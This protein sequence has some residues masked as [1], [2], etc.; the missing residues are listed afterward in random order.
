[1]ILKVKGSDPDLRPAMT[2]SNVITTDVLDSVLFVPLESVFSNDTLQYVFVKNGNDV[3]KQIVDPGAENENYTVVNEGVKADE[4]LMLTEPKNADKL[5][6]EG[7]EIYEKIQQRKL[8][9]IENL[10]KSVTQ[11]EGQVP[12]D[13]SVVKGNK[14]RRKKKQK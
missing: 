3:R 13:R 14:K 12:S 2:T 1:V 8:E 4:I 10:K 11:K 7:V 6:F 9:E 5:P